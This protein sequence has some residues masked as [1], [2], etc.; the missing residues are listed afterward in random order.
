MLLEDSEW[1]QW[2]DREIAR[3][4]GVGNKFVGDARASIC[5]PNTDSPAPATRTVTRN[6]TT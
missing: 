2:S 6:G 1:V 3:Q 5:V 4:V